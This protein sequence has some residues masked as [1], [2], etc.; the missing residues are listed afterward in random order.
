MSDWQIGPRPLGRRLRESAKSVL[1]ALFLVILIRATLVQAYHIPSGSM[2]DTLFEGDYLLS[3]K[4]TFGTQIPDR[5]PILNVKLPSLRMPGLRDPGP[6]DLVIFECPEDPSRDCIK[7][8]IAV[9]GQTVEIRS[10]VVTV[11]GRP[12]EDP[13][14]VKY[15]DRRQLPKRS[16]ARDNYGPYM[17]PPGHIFVMGDNRD[18][19]YDSRFWGPVSV[20]RIKA[21]PFLIYLSVD[22]SASLWNPFE[23]IRWGRLGPID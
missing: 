5:L 8:C 11:D 17:V 19:S 4:L 6:G 21:H 9:E 18:N 2:E 14:G 3:D 7:R 15:E 12:F 10:K 22:G 13:R 23:K 20:G 1:A 16:S